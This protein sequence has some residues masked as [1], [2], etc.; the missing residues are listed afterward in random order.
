MISNWFLIPHLTYS[1]LRRVKVIGMANRVRSVRQR[2]T[3]LVTDKGK[4]NIFTHKV[5]PVTAVYTA[6]NAMGTRK[7]KAVRDVKLTTQS[8]PLPKLRMHGTIPPFTKTPPWR[9]QGSY[10]RLSNLSCPLS[11]HLASIFFLI[12]HKFCNLNAS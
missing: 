7:L 11:R 4:G 8:H 12:C 3:C 10:K 5:Q 1:T 6:H 2:N 9:A